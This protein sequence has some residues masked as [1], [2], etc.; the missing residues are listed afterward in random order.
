MEDPAIQN[1]EGGETGRP[2]DRS[3]WIA[4]IGYLAFLCFFSM[5]KAKKDSFI[6][7]HARQGFMLFLAECVVLVTVVILEL[8]IGKL[9]FIG[10]VI[11]GLIQLVTG[12]GA[13]TISVV[14]FVKALFGE[15]WHLPFLGDYAE[16]V[17]DLKSTDR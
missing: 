3:R 2:A 1:N 6:H 4:A 15:H 16:R 5:W 8:T 9:R 13:L 11:V 10:L 7:F 12:L 17:P 14:G